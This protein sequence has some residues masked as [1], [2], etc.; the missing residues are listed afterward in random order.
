[1]STTNPMFQLSIFIPRP[2]FCPD[3]NLTPVQPGTEDQDP[4][5]AYIE[6]MLPAQGPETIRELQQSVIESAEG[7]WLGSIGLASV[8]LDQNGNPDPQ[9]LSVRNIYGE[10]AE[11]SSAFQSEKF[12]DP[13]VKR[14]LLAVNIDYNEYTARLHVIRLRDVLYS[15]APGL[16]VGN[17]TP[18]PPYDPSQIGIAGAISLFPSVRGDHGNPHANPPSPERSPA[19]PPGTGSSKNKKKKKLPHP[20]PAIVHTPEAAPATAVQESAIVNLAN[21]RFN[22][23]NPFAAFSSLRGDQPETREQNLPARYLKSFALSTWNSPP[24]HYRLRGHY[25]YLVITTLENVSYDITCHTKGFYV[26]KSSKA[27]FDPSPSSDSTLDSVYFPTLTQLICTL[28]PAFVKQVSDTWNR[29]LNPAFPDFF[30]SISITNCLPAFPWLVN[31]EKPTPDAIRS[32]LAYLITGSTTAETLPPARD[33]ADEFAQAR[34]LPRKSLSER[35]LRERIWSRLQS[36]FSMAA[37]RGVISCSRGEVPALNPQ[38][39]ESAWTYVLNNILFSRAEDPIGA[40][41]HLGGTAAA[42]AIASKDLYSIKHLNQLDVP[43]IYT[44]GS[45]VIDYHGKRWIAQGMIPGI[46][47]P[48]DLEAEKA[49]QDLAVQQSQIN[50]QSTHDDKDEGDWEKVNGS[51][52]ATPELGTVPVPDEVSPPTTYDI[53]YGS[54]DIEKP[55]M[56]LRSDPKFHRLASHVASGFNLNEHDVTD[57]N[58]R[59]HRLWL[60]ADV[61]GIRATDGRCYL[62]DLYR[63]NPLDVYFI[64]N[65]IN[66]PILDGKTPISDLPVSQTPVKSTQ[67][68]FP[69]RFTVIRME[70]VNAFKTHKFRQ[71]AMK[72]LQRHKQKELQQAAQSNLDSKNTDKSIE[73]SA[74]GLG[75]EVVV[76]PDTLADDASDAL[77]KES[78]EFALNPDAFVDRK[79]QPWTIPEDEEDESMALVK[80]L[81]KYVREQLLPSVVQDLSEVK[82][83]PADGRRLSDLLHSHG[84]NIRYLGHITHRLQ[85]AANS[86]SASPEN[87]DDQNVVLQAS[88]GLLQSEMVFRAC[89][90]ILNQMLLTTSE[91]E[92]CPCI[93]H[94][95][96]C[97]LGQSAA[98]PSSEPSLD[99]S[100]TWRTC[101]RQSLRSQITSAIRRHFRYALPSSFFT[102]RLPR[103]KIQMLREIC[104]RMGIQMCLRDYNL[105]P[106]SL[107]LAPNGHAQVVNEQVQKNAETLP[108]TEEPAPATNGQTNSTDDENSTEGATPNESSAPSAPKNIKKKKK[109]KSKKGVASPSASV[110]GQTFSPN[111]ILNLLPIVRDSTCR[112]SV[113]D[114]LYAEGRKA[115]SN[116]DIALGQELCTDAL[117]TYE[118]VFGSIHPE[119]CRH[120]HSLAILY[121]QLSQRA[122]VELSEYNDRLLELSA[123]Y[124][125]ASNE[126]DREKLK[127][128]IESYQRDRE[129][130][131]VKN[132]I[133]TYIQLAANNLRQ[134]VIVAERVLGLDHPETIQQYSDLSVMEYHLGNTDTA[135]RYTNHALELWHLVYGPGCHPDASASVTHAGVLAQSTLDPSKSPRA[136]SIFALSRSLVG[137]FFG[138]DSGKFAEA[139]LILSQMF[140]QGGQKEQAIKY[141]LEAKRLYACKYGEDHEQTQHAN[142]LHESI[143]RSIEAQIKGDEEKSARLAKRLGLDPK[144]AAT[145]RARLLASS[146]S[147]TGSS[148]EWTLSR[149]TGP[150]E[151]LIVQQEPL[152]QK[153]R[154]PASNGTPLSIDDLVDYIQGTSSKSSRASNGLTNAKNSRQSP[155]KNS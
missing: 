139:T 26:N 128:R 90:H 147:P 61:H 154:P 8:E 67:D 12:E 149:R 83:L 31:P 111:D 93:S 91:S 148:A 32:Q 60:S 42:R 105:C 118:Q 33:W 107:E 87:K 1:M 72:H 73:A 38:E 41:E 76:D 144:R 97:L 4:D 127:Q 50:G 3:V 130:E 82:G 114:E 71:F 29:A 62:I 45:A 5:S 88:I 51:S 47:R 151:P 35:I 123:F 37:T 138:S 142:S 102:Q 79:D 136:D 68:T 15:Q 64:Q 108:T 98:I 85:L 49:Q 143:S 104:T 96:N 106:P 77:D 135:M 40:Y 110:D 145:L 20:T 133:D 22:P 81:S 137:S 74:D 86:L 43:G 129:P 69:H 140:A 52:P 28:S 94:F 14:A 27:Q 21:Y 109:S 125:A 25:L 59:V 132:E 36:D 103:T 112:S 146:A 126:D 122:L 95:L 44:M 89:K 131:A 101:T 23:A 84:V 121:H 16:L 46:F 99:Q 11:L 150:D 120:W 56:G 78:F 48:P 34:E 18:F 13:T 66:G 2:N 92:A 65:D 55:E 134:S 58:G 57:V 24:H 7:W 9:R 54:A 75:E 19:D 17:S 119:M 152:S 113:A 63:M 6:L 30:T 100:S 70:A 141:G 53:L 10:F 39:P 115:F 124:H 117:T 155:V 80:E 153:V 116:G